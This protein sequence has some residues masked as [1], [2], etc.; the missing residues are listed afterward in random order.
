MIKHF[1]SV[2]IFIFVF[3]FIYFV[4]SIYVSDNNKI[5][6][7]SNR[8]NVQSS[9][10]QKLLILPILKNDTNNV[11]EFNSGYED[12]NNKIKRNFWNLFK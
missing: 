12:N 7:S 8:E 1:I 2:L 11:I 4:I 9:V 10:E 5:K 6:V 3:L